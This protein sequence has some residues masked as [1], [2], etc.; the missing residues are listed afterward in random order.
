MAYAQ[1]FFANFNNSEA[2]IG[3]CNSM[4]PEEETKLR[5][6]ERLIHVLET[7]NGVKKLVK[8][9]C[10]SAADRTMA[11]PRLLRPYSV[12]KDTVDYLLLEVAK[13][14]DVPTSIVYDFIDDRL[15]AV[16]QD[17][18]IQR[19]PSEQCCNLLEPMIRFYVYYGYILC[20]LPI[21]DFDPVLNKKH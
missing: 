15:R 12:L 9:Y 1:Y 16:R 17:I 18:T 7:E 3:T 6:K 11:V 20:K 2:V 19:L 4:C 10:R 8:A 13:R 21:K 5:E 14:T